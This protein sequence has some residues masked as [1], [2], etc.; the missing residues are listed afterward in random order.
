MAVVRVKTIKTRKTVKKSHK[1]LLCLT[2]KND[3]VT[4]QK[5]KKGDKDN[6]YETRYSWKLEDL[7][8]ADGNPEE[9]N[10]RAFSLKFDKVYRWQADTHEERDQFL[11]LLQKL[12]KRY[13]KA[14]GPKFV[15]YEDITSSVGEANFEDETIADRTQLNPTS[16][17]SPGLDIQ[18]YED[19][20]EEV[21]L[22]AQQ[23][24][25]IDEVLAGRDWSQN[26]AEEY[27][28]RLA[29][30]L[31]DLESDN[32]E[33]II[34]SEREIETLMDQLDEALLTLD[35]MDV[36]IE[37]YNSILGTVKQDVMVVAEQNGIVVTHTSNENAL[38]KEL[39]FVTDFLEFPNELVESLRNGDLSN[40]VV[41]SQCTE[42]VKILAAKRHLSESMS[43]GLKMM[44]A[45][46]DMIASLGK[47]Q[48]KFANRLVQFFLDYL[49]EQ[50][51]QRTAHEAR[52]TR[53]QPYSKLMAWLRNYEP[54]SSFSKFSGVCQA[55]TR[56]LHPVYLQELKD[57]CE[58]AKSSAG[59]K[60][61]S[62]DKDDWG[63]RQQFDTVFN[64]LLVDTTNSRIAEQDFCVT[65]FI[66][67]D[68]EQKA[69]RLQQ[70]RTGTGQSLKIE[71][72]PSRRMES[73][74]V[75]NQ[76]EKE[77]LAGLFD[78]F[79]GEV[80]TFI[81]SAEKSDGFNIVSIMHRLWQVSEATKDKP[82]L[83]KPI[84]ALYKEC[85][86]RFNTYIDNWVKTIEDGKV[87]KKNNLGILPFC[88]RFATVISH[89]EKIVHGANEAGRTIVDFA[90][91]RMAAAVI[92]TIDRMAKECKYPNVAVFENFHH[93]HHSLSELKIQ[94][95]QT[96]RSTS[97][98]KYGAALNLYVSSILGRPLEKLS[99]FFE[100]VERLIQAGTKP[101][102]VGYQMAFSKQELKK[103]ISQYPGKEVKKNLEGL[104]RRVD[105]HLCDE[106]RLL[107][108]VWHH[109]Q[110]EFVKQYN[111]FE[112]L[113]ENCYPGAAVTLEFNV[114]DLLNYF[115]SIAKPNS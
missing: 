104:Y 51:K 114:Q 32:F 69:G 18:V 8:L 90:M 75:G 36:T 73:I 29:Q 15:N 26:D 37:K 2:A 4:L 12:C 98:E 103:V 63:R 96:F 71:S 105:R 76:R 50:I 64:E 106:E 3:V 34:R 83:R 17:L 23:E 60:G 47:T 38:L 92:T 44:T 27:S 33:A 74:S 115:N 7:V 10:D 77:M 42:A 99:A 82:L 20:D 5:L 79:R 21:E 48:D 95:L 113:I 30:Q 9:K 14:P 97:K 111:R 66:E 91:T 84:I 93:L 11:F 52:R 81:E 57:G 70:A 25:D 80:I 100:A 68:E 72:V 61:K 35:E 86:T 16:P 101:E 49:N 78:G 46:A 94:C 108:V 54:K 53:L 58:R 45:V 13:L 109:M 6:T 24:E 89:M 41:V 1:S 59:L 112:E 87:P 88:D 31:S 55:Y 28:T 107:E 110:Q 85:K 43:D 62:A 56:A 19:S 40:L 65:Y 39:E 22:T 102:E 67:S